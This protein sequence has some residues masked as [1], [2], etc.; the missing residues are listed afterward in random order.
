MARRRKRRS[1]FWIPFETSLSLGTLL[2]DIVL[3]AGIL[4]FGEDFFVVSVRAA[5]S[6]RGATAGEGPIVVGYAHGDLTVTEIAEAIAAEVT[7]P[8]D[9]IAKERAR[10]PVRLVGQMATIDAEGS[11]ADGEVRSRA[12]RFSVGDGHALNIWAQNQSGATLTT[13]NNLQITGHILGRW[14]R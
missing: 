7:D 8:D 3:A 5:W 10:R 9:I 14:Q 12:I 11:L 4:T 2:N 1:L 13:G 6:W